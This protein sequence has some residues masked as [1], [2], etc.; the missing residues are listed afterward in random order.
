MDSFDKASSFD[1]EVN[2]RSF[3]NL[4]Y[5]EKSDKSAINQLNGTNSEEMLK[6]DALDEIRKKN[7][8]H[9]MLLF[10]FFILCYFFYCYCLFIYFYSSLILKLT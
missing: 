3:A 1:I 6:N 10:I 9:Q 8:K 2:F 5:T 7:P 4:G